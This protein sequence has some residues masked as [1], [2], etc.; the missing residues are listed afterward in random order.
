GRPSRGVFRLLEDLLRQALLQSTFADP[1]NPC[2]Y[3]QVQRLRVGK[4]YSNVLMQLPDVHN[5]VFDAEAAL[6]PGGLPR[7]REHSTGNDRSTAQFAFWTMG[8]Q[9][10]AA[11]AQ[12]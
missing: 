8:Q 3:G 11:D 1:R 6:L 7:S 5:V 2:A 10:L 9:G 4:I 12:E